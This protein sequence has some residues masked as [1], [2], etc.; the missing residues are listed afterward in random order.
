[1]THS[2]FFNALCNV[3]LLLVSATLP[4]KSIRLNSLSVGLLVLVCCANKNTLKRSKD[5]ITDPIFIGLTC[6]FFVCLFSVLYSQNKAVAWLGIETTVSLMILP[7][8]ILSCYKNQE[9]KLNVNLF[10][11]G[12]V[13]AT[14]ST[15]LTCLAATFIKNYSNGQSFSFANNW[16]Y[17]ADSLVEK[18]GFHASYFSIYCAFSIF[19]LLYFIKLKKIK[20]WMAVL[21]I[22]YLMAFQFL[23]ASRVGILSLML[24]VVATIIYEAYCQRKLILGLSISGLFLLITFISLYSFGTMRDKIDAMINYRVDQ[25][26]A[27]FKVDGRLQEWQASFELFSQNPILG[28][29]LG[30]RKSELEKVYLKNGFS[31]G[32]EN[33]YDSHNLILDTAVGTGL[34][35]LAS[36]F[37]LFFVSIK[38]CIR[39]IKSR[40]LLYFQFLSLFFLISAVEASFSVQKG[41]VFFALINSLLLVQIL[42][43]ENKKAMPADTTSRKLMSQKFSVK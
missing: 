27:A 3:A 2:K 4:T 21:P 11:A 42:Q 35:G 17:S 32:Y 16:V 24:I 40:N 30:D 7:L 10:L 28:V 1:M 20:Y 18:W 26:N 43:Y 38:Y 23:L 8:A 25:Y 36:L 9:I 5:V 15:S 41:M 14:I 6:Y 34:L 37:A 19:I 39:S 12:F 33:R 13:V 22:I 29:G 31:E